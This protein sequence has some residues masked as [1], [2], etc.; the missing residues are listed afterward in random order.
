MDSSDGVMRGQQAAAY[1]EGQQAKAVKKSA[2][3]VP[4]PAYWV[5]AWSGWL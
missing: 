3:P 5:A 1:L 4:M 2:Y